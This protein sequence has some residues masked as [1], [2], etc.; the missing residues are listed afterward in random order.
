MMTDKPKIGIS[1]RVV[2]AP[3]YDETRDALSQDW[4]SLLEEL[5]FF[6]LVPIDGHSFNHLIPI[7]KNI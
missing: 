7:L 1:L 2:Q 6:Y 3:N 4:P 5:G